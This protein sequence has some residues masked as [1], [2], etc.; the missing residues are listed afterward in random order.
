MLLDI[1][2]QFNWIDL[3][4]V[5]LFLKIAYVSVKNGFV[6]ELFKLLGTVFSIYIAFHYFTILSDMF[7]RRVPEEQ[8]FPLEFMDFLTCALL[9]L[10]IYLLFVLLRNLLCHFVKMEAVPALSKWGGLLLG[11]G[12]GIIAASLVVFLLFISTISYLNASAKGSYIGQ[13]VFN[14][15]IST[16]EAAWNGLMNKLVTGE[17]FNNTLRE[18][19]KE[20]FKK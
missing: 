20:Y 6:V 1:L 19:Q 11:L 17:K 4:I 7:M 14:V 16:Y 5:L 13:R 15:S 2:R 9:L 10:V 8:A 12:R 3:V 18:I